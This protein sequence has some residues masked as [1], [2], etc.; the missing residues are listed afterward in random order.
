M[1]ASRIK[2]LTKLV[3]LLGTPVV[4]LA[5][6]FSCGVYCGHEHR[7]T[8]LKFERD[9]LGMD[10]T[11][12]GEPVPPKVEP[13]KTEPPKTEPK[14]EP[15]KVEP[16]KVEP[17][18][19]P[20]KV[21]PVPPTTEPVVLARVEDPVP[22]PVTEPAPL[23]GDNFARFSEPVRVTVKVLV[24]PALATRRPDW[25]AYVQ[26]HVAWSSQV[27][28]K[29][30]GLHLDL[31]GIVKM[32]DTPRVLTDLQG[33]AREGADLLL[34]FVN[35]E[36]SPVQANVLR[37]GNLD[38]MLV[39]ATRGPRAG[40]LRG[41]LLA[42]G[43]VFGAEVL[44]PDSEEARAGSWMAGRLAADEASPIKLDAV[45]R[46]TMLAHKTMPF[47]SATAAAA[48]TRPSTPPPDRLPGVGDEEPSPAD[49]D[50]EE[51]P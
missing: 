7:T 43:R 14:V 38:V 11:V 40:H 4:V 49:D 9:W 5:G 2:N 6:L 26:R 48:P 22:F 24:D 19:E 30:V 36:Y 28:E 25:L 21:E 17:K 1:A 44:D 29:W 45:N 15:P 18:V 39:H 20:P 41:L 46:V 33:Y 34:V 16:P 32:E 12:P 37:D 42:L 51:A 23:S 10:V 47:A 8:V 31:H 27:L 50:E 35:D 3:L 13:P